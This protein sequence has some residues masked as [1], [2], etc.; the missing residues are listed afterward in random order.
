MQNMQVESS[1]EVQV[2]NFCWIPADTCSEMFNFER[3]AEAR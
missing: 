2:G 1:N 3:V